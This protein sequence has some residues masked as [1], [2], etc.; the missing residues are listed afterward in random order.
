MLIQLI[1]KN[2]SSEKKALFNSALR[3]DYFIILSELLQIGDTS[4]KYEKKKKKKKKKKK[5]KQANNQI[6]TVSVSDVLVHTK[7]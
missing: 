1:S 3:L 5:N 4:S 6:Y 2:F 7:T